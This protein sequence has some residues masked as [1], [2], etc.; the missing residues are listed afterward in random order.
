MIR[1]LKFA[2]LFP[3]SC[4]VLGCGSEVDLGV[5]E[6]IPGTEM[7]RAKG[8]PGASISIS[9]D[10][11][12]LVF[13][14]FIQP[15]SEY[16]QRV[17]R[18]EKNV[19]G[20]RFSSLNLNSMEKTEY[21]HPAEANDTINR[22]F[23]TSFSEKGWADGC[24]Y[25]NI[26]FNKENFVLKPGEPALVLSGH[27]PQNASCSDCLANT[28]ENVISLEGPKGP[29]LNEKVIFGKRVSPD[30]KLVAYVLG[31]RTWNLVA[32]TFRGEVYLMDLETRKKRRVF[33]NRN[34]SNLMWSPDSKRLY[35]AAETKA[36]RSNRKNCGIYYVEVGRV[37]EN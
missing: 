19:P 18:Q 6:G 2:L 23:P 4:F 8:S 20:I 31:V 25:T 22:T 3:V 17:E 28:P 12:W 36:Y 30:G 21:E 27:Y 37:F 15:F 7:A 5:A 10:G 32:R 33:K 34:L 14:E 24:F 26:I 16:I 13:A 9:S 1:T 11:K 35:F 29:S